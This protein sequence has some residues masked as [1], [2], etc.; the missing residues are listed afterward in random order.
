M[1]EKRGR[2]RPTK[3]TPELTTELLKLI[4]DGNYAE[5]AAQAVGIDE[6]T[7]YRWKEQ[8][9][10]DVAAGRR[11]ALADFCEAV[12]RARA[13]AE[14]YYVGLIKSNAV[15]GKDAHAAIEVLARSRPQRW[16]K[17][18][19]LDAKVEHAGEV[20]IVLKLVDNEPD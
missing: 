1:A 9:E 13:K 11:T 18:D 20:K 12:S 16:A 8:G 14:T 10:A 7:Y 17:K 2:G 6:A 4:E 15:A 19:R 5:V 3:L